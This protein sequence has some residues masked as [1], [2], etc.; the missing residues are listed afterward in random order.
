MGR[1]VIDVQR[2]HIRSVHSR[3]R[4]PKSS[5]IHGNR[6]LRPPHAHPKR[7]GNPRRRLTVQISPQVEAERV[8]LADAAGFIISEEQLKRDIKHWREV[9]TLESV[10]EDHHARHRENGPNEE[11]ATRY[12]ANDPRFAIARQIIT[13][14]GHIETPPDFVRTRR[15]APFC[16]KQTRLMPVYYKAVAEMHDKHNVLLFRLSDLT[17]DELKNLH[18][19]N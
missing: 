14:D 15:T 1:V 12:L 2:R 5:C 10:I 4:R 9:G 17:P 13:E 8:A 11:H 6:I 7:A 3:C 19:A 18:C 16:H